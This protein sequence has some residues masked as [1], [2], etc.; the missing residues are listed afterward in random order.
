M[1]VVTISALLGGN[2]LHII[3]ILDGL[4]SYI[5]ITYAYN[6][7]NNLFND[8]YYNITKVMLVINIILAVYVY[9]IR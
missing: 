8:T 5:F 3:I 9:V 6:K 7:N 4:I 2:M 1:L